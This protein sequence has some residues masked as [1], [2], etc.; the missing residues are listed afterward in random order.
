MARNFK[1]GEY[2]D[3][4]KRALEGATPTAS[5]WARTKCPFCIQRVGTND[6]RGSLAHRIADGYVRCF[7]CGV[8]LWLHGPNAKP[9]I[10][11]EAAPKTNFL[12]KGAPSW[13]TPL[14]GFEAESSL[15]LRPGIEYAE[16]RGFDAAI[17]RATGMGAALRGKYTDRL[18]TPHRHRNGHWWG[19]SARS[20]IPKHSMP[21]LYPNNMSRDY[22]YNEQV[23]QTETDDPALLQE[24]VLDG[25]LYFPDCVCALG[26]P[27]HIHRE[28]L[29]KARRPIVVVLDADAS[30]EGLRLAWWLRMQ[31]KAAGCVW[32]PPGR[33]PNDSVLNPADVRRAAHVSV[34]VQEPV[35]IEEHSPNLFDD[36]EFTHIFEG[37][38]P[39]VP[40]ARD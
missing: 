36:R 3:M 33:D 25:L 13:Y 12:S 18:I 14:F 34:G 2:R 16:S 26:Q 21:H 8:R 39:S 27:T 9:R 11:V 10:E 40:G 6:R 22:M 5:G 37:E 31:G 28:T 17:R 19:Y 30:M 32:L 4:A 20:W 35:V 23:L 15:G 7:R 1:G 29:L 38:K 24:G